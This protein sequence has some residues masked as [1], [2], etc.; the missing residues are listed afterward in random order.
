MRSFMHRRPWARINHFVVGTNVVLAPHSIRGIVVD[1]ML[2]ASCEQIS[3]VVVAFHT[4]RGGPILYKPIRWN[5]LRRVGGAFLVNASSDAI[6][7]GLPHAFAA[8]SYGGNAIIEGTFIPTPQS[9]C[10]H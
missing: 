9:V 3:Y 6:E 5:L 4:G 10:V 7:T 2:D 1:L 8:M